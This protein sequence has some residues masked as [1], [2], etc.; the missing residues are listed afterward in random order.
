MITYHIHFGC[1]SKLLSMME[2]PNQIDCGLEKYLIELTVFSEDV[3]C[4]CK[5]FSTAFFD[6][7]F[8]ALVLVLFSQHTL[9]WSIRFMTNGLGKPFHLWGWDLLIATAIVIYLQQQSFLIRPTVLL[10]LFRA[11]TFKLDMNA[12]LTCWWVWLNYWGSQH[13]PFTRYWDLRRHQ[14]IFSIFR[15][16]RKNWLDNHQQTRSE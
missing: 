5:K 8:T 1:Q 14:G 2:D 3:F 13:E 7:I 12:K 16:A 10:K 15:P 4:C 11:Q 6:L 9:F